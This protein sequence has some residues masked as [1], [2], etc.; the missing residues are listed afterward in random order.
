MAHWVKVSQWL[1]GELNLDS[2]TQGN[3]A[4][5]TPWHSR[6]TGREDRE[7]EGMHG[8]ASLAESNKMD[9]GY[10]D[11]HHNSAVDIVLIWTCGHLYSCM[12]TPPH[13]HI[14]DKWKGGG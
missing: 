4:F 10:W 1:S 13:T 9:K 7:S 11:I 5:V 2:T 8:S 3:T 12:H 6:L 14:T